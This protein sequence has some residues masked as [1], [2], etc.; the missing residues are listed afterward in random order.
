MAHSL[1]LKVIAEG[2]EHQHQLEFLAEN[3][4]DE[5]QGY[6]LSR[7]VPATEMTRLMQSRTVIPRAHSIH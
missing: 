1:L 6:L 5:V 3:E 2:V 4:C 7:P